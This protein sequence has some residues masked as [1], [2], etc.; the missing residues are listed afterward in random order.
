MNNEK[1]E[2]RSVVEIATQLAERQM[3]KGNGLLP[4]HHPNK[5]FF[6]CELFDYALK[7][8]G[9]SMEAPIFTL[10][11]KPDLSVWEWK[12]KD[13]LSS[14]KVTPSVLGRATQ[15]D[16]DILIYV[17]SQL[18][19]AMNQGKNDLVSR[20]VRFRVHDY[21]VTTNRTT[22]GH[23]YKSMEM[24]LERLRGTSITTNIKTGGRRTK[25][26]FGVIDSWSIVEKSPTD[27][28]MIAVEVTLSKWLFN[29][30]Q[31]HE[32]LTLNRNYFRLR[33]P[34]ERRIYEIARKH[35]GNQP[36]F[37]IDLQLL[38]NKCGSQSKLYEFRR[39]IREL[40]EV[41]TLPDYVMKLDD[42]KDQVS[43]TPRPKFLLSLSD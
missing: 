16:K 12:S 11:T 40:I 17:I 35:C 39:S 33:K 27:S 21:L 5:D 19:E 31:A 34:I 15:F 24:A 43:F 26:G 18:T 38:Q 30:V 37:L 13:G 22:G 2:N 8:D 20:T 29:A 32:V 7:D 10:A 14:V 1:T 28:R 9:A 4:I 25:E 6:L 3:A 42:T 36:R 23:D 41:D